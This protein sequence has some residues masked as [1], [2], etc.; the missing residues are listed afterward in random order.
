MWFVTVL[1]K[2]MSKVCFSKMGKSST[3]GVFSKMEKTSVYPIYIYI[4]I[5]I[6]FSVENQKFS[7]TS[8][9]LFSRTQIHKMTALSRLIH[10][11]IIRES[12]TNFWIWARESCFRRLKVL[13][14][15]VFST[16]D[17]YRIIYIYHCP[18]RGKFW[19][20]LKSWN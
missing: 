3:Q 18:Y 2:N 6:H 15:L 16:V 1:R 12:T 20:F 9:K 14:N 17:F 19:P 11:I 13:L 4:Y 10:Q 5:Y 7:P 8:E